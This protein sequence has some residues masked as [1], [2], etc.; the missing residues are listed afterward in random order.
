M[1][2]VVLI[3]VGAAVVA[4]ARNTRQAVVRVPIAVERAT[5]RRRS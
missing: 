2:L 4:Q 3:L 5:P 1:A